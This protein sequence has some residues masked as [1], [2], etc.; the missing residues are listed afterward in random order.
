MS[1]FVQ[2]RGRDLVL[3]SRPT[4][5]CGCNYGNWMLVEHYMIGLPW[6]EYM[7]RNLWLEMLGRDSFEAFW[8]T[9]MDGYATDEDFAF[10]KSLGC[11]MIQLPFN[12]RF[13]EDPARDR[14]AAGFE[15]RGFEYVDRFLNMARRHGIHVLLSMHAVPGVAVRDWNAESAYGEA[16][17]WDHEHFQHRTEELWTAIATRYRNDPIVFGYEPV[18]EPFTEDADLFHRV[19]LRL[20][21]AI[22]AADPRHI[23]VLNSNRWGRQIG[24]LR[25]EIFEDPQ[26]MPSFHQYPM[27]FPLL[28]G[29]KR[30]PGENDG[31]MVDRRDVERTFDETTDTAR[32]PRP[33]L[34]G[35]FGGGAPRLGPDW[36][37]SPQFAM[38]GD[39]MD[40]CLERRFP[41][42][43]W[44]FK[45]L[46]AMGVVSPGPDTP[47]RR[48]LAEP[49]VRAIRDSWGPV[50]R[51]LGELAA[52]HGKFEAV[53]Q[54]AF[55]PSDWRQLLGF[56]CHHHWD[57][58]ALP[59]VL[60]QLKR[61][62]QRDLE[63]MAQ[64]FH[65]RNCA[66]CEPRRELLSRHGRAAQEMNAR[67]KG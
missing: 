19:T 21:R 33:H 51:G 16:F 23:I 3:G 27:T 7:M 26:V 67:A 31:R 5:F 34:M 66:V 42:N 61:Y 39:M 45:D 36:A 55:I 30:Y 12:Y 46:G 59:A 2:I 18:N 49:A 47:W 62:G 53:E 41:W 28:R 25:D 38:L 6:T 48:F 13:F 50:G 63:E 65:F 22:R 29:V 8:H 40:I 35:E 14:T 54:D 58:V 56:Q 9:F 10:M 17:Y 60:R 4:M 52:E 57:A 37:T 32:I 15:E 44:D 11:N 20:A 1:D 24:S 43:F 64:S